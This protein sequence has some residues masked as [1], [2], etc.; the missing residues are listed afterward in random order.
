MARSFVFTFAKTVSKSI[1]K[2]S[3][4]K[5]YPAVKNQ[6]TP[7]TRGQIFNEIEKCI[8]C[9]LCERKCPTHAIT[10]SRETKE[11]DLRSL[12][13]IACGACVE[14]CPK[15]CLIMRN[16]Y[17]EAVYQREQGV[18]HYKQKVTVEEETANE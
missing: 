4:T 5:M 16:N 18:Y 11:F 2:K 1:F 6:Y 8:F 7:V 15:K 17:S 14:V 9:G 10:V 3:A 12:Q 13:C